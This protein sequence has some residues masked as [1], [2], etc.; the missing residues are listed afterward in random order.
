MDEITKTY[1]IYLTLYFEISIFAA[2]VQKS[3][4]SLAYHFLCGIIYIISGLCKSIRR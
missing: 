1:P 2:T 3:K 4:R